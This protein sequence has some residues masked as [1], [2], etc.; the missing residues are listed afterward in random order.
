[1]EH[2]KCSDMANFHEHIVADTFRSKKSI[3]AL[4]VYEQE[5]PQKWCLSSC[6]S[7]PCGDY[8]R[9]RLFNIIDDIT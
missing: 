7:T 1:M 8:K 3:S 6:H 2:N 4:L 9:L 5:A